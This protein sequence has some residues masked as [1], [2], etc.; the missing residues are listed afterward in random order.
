MET[1]R[2]PKYSCT[3]VLQFADFCLVGGGAAPP[4]HLDQV[5]VFR[6]N[7]CG[8][9]KPVTSHVLEVATSFKV[10]LQGIKHLRSPVFMVTCADD[11]RVGVEGIGAEIVK[12]LVTHDLV[13]NRKMLEP[14]D[15]VQV[16]HDKVCRAFGHPRN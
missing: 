10:G 2:S 9:V 14:M 3:A 15:D 5:R 12:I 13:S 8:P 16:R 7:R 4:A 1:P 6:M 11:C